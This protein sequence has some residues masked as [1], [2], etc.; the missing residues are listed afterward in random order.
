MS[1]EAIDAIVLPILSLFFDAIVKFLHTFA[2]F[3]VAVLA[4]S[5]GIAVVIDSEP[6]VMA[7]K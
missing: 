2:P 7:H 4:P 5:P 6:P 3:G 1:I